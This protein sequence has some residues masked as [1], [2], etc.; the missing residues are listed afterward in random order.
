MPVPFRVITNPGLLAVNQDVLGIQES[1]KIL[2][3]ENTA[4]EVAPPHKLLALFPITLSANTAFTAS[5]VYTAHTASTPYTADTYAYISL[6]LI[7]KKSSSNHHHT[8]NSG[9]LTFPT[10]NLQIG[11]DFGGGGTWK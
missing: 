10:L 1:S 6:H 8:M 4:K 7:S 5:T 11:G 3:E 9:F 2:K